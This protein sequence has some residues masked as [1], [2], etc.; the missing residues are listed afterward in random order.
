MLE[1]CLFLLVLNFD[2]FLTGLAF[3]LVGIHITFAASVLIAGCSGLFF[4]G[5]MIFGGIL[6]SI[7]PFEAFHDLSLLFLFLLALFLISKYCGKESR[8]RFSGLWRNPEK[9]DSNAD[10]VISAGE[11]VALGVAIAL[12]ALVGGL[13]FGF[14]GEN[15]PFWASLTA[16]M[17][18]VLLVGANLLGKFLCK[19]MRNL[20]RSQD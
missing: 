5:G 14:I 3:G 4:G 19:N 12:D 13:A 1:L 15:V 7:L 6:L 17:C 9:Q 10:E 11:G 2:A 8:G 18:Y 20:H 16:L